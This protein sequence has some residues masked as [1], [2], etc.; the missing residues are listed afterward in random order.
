MQIT[1]R[2]EDWSLF[3]DGVLRRLGTGG[4]ALFVEAL[5][6]SPAPLG[7]PLADQSLSKAF[8]YSEM[9]SERRSGNVRA[10]EK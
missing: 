9:A 8:E 6:I 5:S 2:Q 10:A 3:D 1:L 4:Q 7:R